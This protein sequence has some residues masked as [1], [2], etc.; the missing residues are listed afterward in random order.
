[1]EKL[2]SNV[3]DLPMQKDSP[4]LACSNKYLC[5]GCDAWRKSA[6]KRWRTMRENAAK[7]GLIKR[8]GGEQ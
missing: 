4:C 8:T 3:P 5:N 7:A 2:W 1:M 6:M